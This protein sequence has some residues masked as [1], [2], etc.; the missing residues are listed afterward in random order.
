VA[1]PIKNAQLTSL[2]L[3]GTVMSIP[4]V[5]IYFALHLLSSKRLFALLQLLGV[6]GNVLANFMLLWIGCFIGVCLSYAFRTVAPTLADL[7]TPDDDYLRPRIRLLFAATLTMLLALLSLVGLVDIQ[8][9][10]YTLSQVASNATLA[11][12][13]GAICGFSE[14]ALPDSVGKK[15]AI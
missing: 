2:A 13:V 14:L 12:V 6:D 9:G 10:T 1:G 5:V 3:W 8:I 11:F 15:L 7:I 4:F